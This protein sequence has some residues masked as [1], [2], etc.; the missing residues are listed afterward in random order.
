MKIRISC[1]LTYIFEFNQG[2]IL[3]QDSFNIFESTRKLHC[4]RALSIHTHPSQTCLSYLHKH[5]EI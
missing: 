5:L 2:N 1:R 3:L 4:S